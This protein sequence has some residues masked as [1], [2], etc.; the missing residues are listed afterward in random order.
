MRGKTIETEKPTTENISGSGLRTASS[1]TASSEKQVTFKYLT[2]IWLQQIIVIV[3]VSVVVGLIKSKADYSV[4]VGGMIY[5]IPNMYFALYAFRFRGA[6]AA[7]FVL[8]S[9]YRGEMGKFLLSGVGFAIAF[10][11]VNP[12]DVLLLFSIYIALTFIQWIQLA[13]IK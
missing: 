5:I 4:L 7:R 9:F 13:T 1:T 8:L 6:H 10:T 12:L 3:V 11:L 2:I